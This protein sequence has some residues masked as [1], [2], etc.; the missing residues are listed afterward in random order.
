M[1]AQFVTLKLT[2]HY[3]TFISITFCFDVVPYSSASVKM[4]NVSKQGF[5]TT[6]R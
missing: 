2:L 4:A 6:V 3:Y 5:V 1:F